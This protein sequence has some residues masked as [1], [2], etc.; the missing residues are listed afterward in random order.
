M[1]IAA[2][3]TDMS[4]RK[5]CEYD[6]ELRNW[7]TFLEEI[8]KNYNVD[9][10]VLNESFE[11]EQREYFLSTSM[12]E[13]ASPD[14][15][16][17]QEPAAL[18]VIDLHKIG[19]DEV[20]SMIETSFTLNLASS[21]SQE[22][23]GN[24]YSERQQH[25][26]F[27]ESSQ[28][29]QHGESCEDAR[30]GVVAANGDSDPHNK[31]GIETNPTKATEC[32]IANEHVTVSGFLGWFDVS[33][34]GSSSSPVPTDRVITLSTS[35]TQDNGTHWGQQAFLLHP[36]IEARAGDVID[37]RLRLTR[38]K[39]NHRLLNVNMDFKH[40]TYVNGTK[41]TSDQIRKWFRME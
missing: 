39:D 9:M 40:H 6:N 38:R 10:G 12:W 7:D 8:A 24:T 11:H 14:Q 33:F 26:H 23:E 20:S 21:A 3:F 28:Q 22:F 5:Q 16:L 13:Q 25:V 32:E 30:V 36:P 35:P 19:L 17:V 31:A 4:Y 15:L 1:Y 29:Q 34:A 18:K 37:G 41:Y 27:D 2:Y